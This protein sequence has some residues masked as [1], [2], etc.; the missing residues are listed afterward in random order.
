[1]RCWFAPRDLLPGQWYH[2]GIEDAI[3]LHTKVLLLL[4][5][6]AVSSKWVDFEEETVRNREAKE[7]CELLFPLR[8]DEAIMQTPQQWAR[9]LRED[10]QIGDFTH[11][12]DEATYQQ[13]FAELLRHLKVKPT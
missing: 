5:E 7:G 8:L 6:A 3:Y 10:R 11:W 2:R 1:V 9:R 13:R 12:Q 4:S